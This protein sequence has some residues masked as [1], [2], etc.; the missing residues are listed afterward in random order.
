MAAY[1][2]LTPKYLNGSMVGYDI[3]ED[4]EAIKTSLRNLFLINVGEVPGKP[5]LGNPISLY[6]FDNIGYF[7]ERTIEIALRNVLDKYEPRVQL[8]NMKI[9]KKNDQNSIDIVINYN[10]LIDNRNVFDSLAFN[11]AH[12]ELT[13]IATRN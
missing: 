1:T 3:V 2:D 8:I 6:V 4:L 5:W 13:M 10:A 7:E 11:L 9:T 12:N